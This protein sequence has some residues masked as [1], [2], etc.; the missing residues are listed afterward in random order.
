MFSK[1]VSIVGARPQFIK[2]ACLSKAIRAKNIHEIIIHTGQHYDSN[3][4]DVFFEEL[5]IPKPDYQLNGKMSRHG[6][7]TAHF[8]TGIENVLIKEQPDLVIVFGDTNST[9]AGALAARK[10]NIPLAHVEAGLR[11]HDLSI[12]ED[13]NR[14]ITDR[15]SDLLFCPSEKA[16]LNLIEEGYN[17]F[18]CKLIKC[19]DIM[20][21]AVLNYSELS[22]LKCASIKLPDNFILATVHRA[23]NTNK[24]YL[25]Q[26]IDALTEI[27]NEIPVIFPLHPRTAKIITELNIKVSNS[28]Q[29]IE[30]LGYLE[31]LHYLK[32][33]SH[34]ITDSG[35]LQKEAYMM[36]KTSLLLMEF[37]P[38]VEL[39]QNKFSIESKSEIKSILENYV[40][41][42]NL[43]PDF[44]IQLYGNGNTGKIIADSITGFLRS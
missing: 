12:P 23:A 11:N 3:M 34:V 7:M 20:Y 30:P 25:P 37:T 36:K 35:G 8:L 2:A 40:L 44:S 39:V 29:L 42:K 14:I 19:G 16:Y 5:N 6:E 18:H 31:M 38:W 10:L 9:L 32:K 4:S 15:I 43:K 1:V 27:S 21:D 41:L 28:I 17:N 24:K 33:C 13:V 22:D 26:I